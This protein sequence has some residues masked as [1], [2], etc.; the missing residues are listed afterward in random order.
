MRWLTVYCHFHV[1]FQH[2]IQENQNNG[3][4]KQ[5]TKMFSLVSL[6]KCFWG[7]RWASFFPQITPLRFS[8]FVKNT[9]FFLIFTFMSIFHEF[10]FLT[11]W[12]LYFSTISSY[13]YLFYMLP[14]VLIKLQAAPNGKS[15]TYYG[16][17]KRSV[18]R[19]DWE[20]YVAIYPIIFTFTVNAKAYDAKYMRYLSLFFLF[21][22]KQT[23]KNW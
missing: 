8:L 2:W 10:L 11:F 17:C 21:N 5:L 13:S 19:N 22:C 7:W 23:A 1:C 3:T 15:S 16:K 20:H 12:N 4:K 9:Y 18:M 14:L 6:N